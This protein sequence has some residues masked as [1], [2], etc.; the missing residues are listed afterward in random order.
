MFLWIEIAAPLT[1]FCQAWLVA[2][3]RGERISGLVVA[4]REQGDK[5]RASGLFSPW[6]F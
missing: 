1:A 2:M 3:F 5:V 6:N 4:V